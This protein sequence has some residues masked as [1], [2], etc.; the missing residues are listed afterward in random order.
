MKIDVKSIQPIGWS[1]QQ[2]FHSC[3]NDQNSWNFGLVFVNT[4]KSSCKRLQV[5]CSHK[6][7]GYILVDFY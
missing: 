1:F 5:T 4:F 6:Q 7:N 3:E 2:L